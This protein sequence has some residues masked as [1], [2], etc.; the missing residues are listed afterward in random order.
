[1]KAPVRPPSVARVT[2]S[3][4]F[5]PLAAGAELYRTTRVPQAGDR[6]G[7]QRQRE[8]AQLAQPGRTERAEYDRITVKSGRIEPRL[9]DGVEPGLAAQALRQ[10]RRDPQE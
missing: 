3:P 5:L 6:A 9:G 4:A 10:L 1:V 8:A 7:R 2:V